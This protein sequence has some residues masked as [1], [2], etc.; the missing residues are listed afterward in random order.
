MHFYVETRCN[1]ESLKLKGKGSMKHEEAQ[2][3]HDYEVQH[4]NE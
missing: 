1:Y 2:I 4:K 3:G